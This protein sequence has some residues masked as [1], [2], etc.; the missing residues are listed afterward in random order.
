MLARALRSVTVAPRALALAKPMM[1]MV[2]SRTM[3]L[4][5]AA[6][7]TTISDELLEK[8]G[9]LSTQSLID[10]LWV[11][12]WPDAF[13]EGARGLEK[14]M[15]CVG[16]A[17]T[18]RFVPQRPDIA[19]DKPIGVESPEYEAFEKCGP[20][21]ILVMASVGPWESVGGDIKFLRLKQLGIGGLV[22]DGSVRDTDELLSYGFPVFSY[23]TTPKQGPAAMQPWECDGVISCGKVVVRPG[24]AVIGDQDGVVVVPA[25]HAQQVYDI[26]HGREVVEVIIKE[27]L[28]KNPGPPGRYYPFKPPIKPESPLGKLLTSKGVKFHH[29]RAGPARS[30]GSQ[31]R[32]MSSTPATMK[33]VVVRENG[34]AENLKYET[35]FPTPTVTDGQVLVKNEYTGINFIDTYFRTGGPAY[36]QQLPFVSGQEGAGTIVEVTPKAVE[37]GLAVGQRVAYSVLGTY[38]EY[39]A[40]PAAKIVNVPDSVGLDVATACMTQGLTAHYLTNHAHAGLVKPGEWMLIHGVG[41]G[42]C[43][44]AAQMAKLKGYKV[45]GTCPEGKEDVGK[46]TGVDE[47]IVTGVMPGTP[48]EDYSSVDIVGKVMEITGGAGVKA[49]IDGIGKSTVDISIE[50]L[51]RRG[52]FVTFGNASGAVPAFP[53]IRLIKKSAFLTRPKLLDYTTTREELMMRA[54]EIFGWVASGEI[55]VGIDRTFDLSDA[56]AGHKFLESGASKGKVIYKV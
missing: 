53:P 39:T 31:R 10:G 47:L 32:H 34:P 25:S 17:T 1:P 44:W 46:A 20:N 52:I 27:E 30:F 3:A 26:A 4:G 16:R 40:V 22:T 54:D 45:I 21:S 24:D 15:K 48:Y 42:T 23:S 36:T 18:L 55:N 35:D 49:V 11:M 33:A 8:L 7:S 38:C 19:M 14:G 12:G 2:A 13:I 28:I 29:T 50:C 5:P 41:G 9:S 37:Q 56:V 51:S 6:S 43:Q